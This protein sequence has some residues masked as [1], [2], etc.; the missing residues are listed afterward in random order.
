MRRKTLELLVCPTCHGELSLSEGGANETI[1]TGMLACA[2][3]Q[4]QYLIKEGIPHFVEP[5]ELVGPNARFARFYDW[6]TH[7]YFVFNNVA[8]FFLGGVRKS[9]KVDIIDRLD[10]AGGRVLE[11]SI[12]PGINL[13]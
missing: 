13:P 10:L 6:F 4:R 7:I 8:F 1:D 3:C 12:G 11:V 5:G 9:R 2:K